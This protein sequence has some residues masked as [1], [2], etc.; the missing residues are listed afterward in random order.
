MPGGRRGECACRDLEGHD[1]LSL[2]LELV[3][4]LEGHAVVS[5]LGDLALEPA[6]SYA[7][8]LGLLAVGRPPNL[9]IVRDAEEQPP[10]FS[11]TQVRLVAEC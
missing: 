11:P 10:A 6:Q 4:L 2:N 3:D 9:P 7:W 5:E 8:R 1:A